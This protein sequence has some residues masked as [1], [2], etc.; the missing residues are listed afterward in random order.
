MQAEL[1]N[2]VAIKKKIMKKY[3]RIRR[4]IFEKPQKS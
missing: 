1:D 3:K 4:N 2:Y